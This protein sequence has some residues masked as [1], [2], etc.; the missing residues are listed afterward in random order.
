[1]TAIAATISELPRSDSK[2]GEISHPERPDTRAS[3][4][5]GSLPVSL[6]AGDKLRK[7]EGL[8]GRVSISARDRAGTFAYPSED[9]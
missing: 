2:L 6:A 1:M 7:Y 3:P 4:D 9:P 8:S 5:S